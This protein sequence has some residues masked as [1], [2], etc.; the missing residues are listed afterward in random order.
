MHFFVFKPIYA[1]V[2]L[3]CEQILNRYSQKDTLSIH[4]WF[5]FLWFQFTHYHSD[6]YVKLIKAFKIFLFGL[7]TQC[8]YAFHCVYCIMHSPLLSR[9]LNNWE[10]IYKFETLNNH[11]CCHS[12]FKWCVEKIYKDG[13]NPSRLNINCD[14]LFRWLLPQLFFYFYTCVFI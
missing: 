14:D 2:Q 8:V 6:D 12:H 13:G 11:N 1:E 3:N 10:G 7:K 9:G 4:N 5:S